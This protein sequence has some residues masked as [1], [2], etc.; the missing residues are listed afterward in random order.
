MI[1]EFAD[2]LRTDMVESMPLVERIDGRKVKLIHNDYNVVFEGLLA[3]T[4]I[5]LEAKYI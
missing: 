1:V 2:T 5:T 4:Y 3:M